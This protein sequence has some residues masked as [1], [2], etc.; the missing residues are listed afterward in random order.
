[1]VPMQDI[2]RRSML[3][4]AACGFGY[5]AFSALAAS[6]ARAAA[7]TQPATAGGPPTPTGYLNPLLPRPS[8]FAPR[9]KR[10]I[11]LFMQGGPSH[12]D[13]FDYKPQ[14]IKDAGKK[15]EKGSLLAPQFAFKQHGKSG[16]WISDLFP[17]IASHADEMCILNGMHTDNPAHPQATIALHT[18][19]VQFVRPSVGAWV[20]YGLGTVNQNLPG[21][22]TINPPGRLGGTQNYGNAFLPAAY[23]GTRI[24]GENGK[25]SQNIP[26]LVNDTMP[27]PMQRRQLDL[28]QSMNRDL[29]ERLGMDHDVEGVIE[30]YELAFR[31][32]STVPEVM[33]TAGESKQTLDL[34][35]INN[36][37]TSRF[38]MQC[39]MAR[40]FA[41]QGVRYIEVCHAG[42]D[43]HNNLKAKLTSNSREIDQPIGALLTDLSQRG[44]LEETLVIWGG[45]FGRT[46]SGQNG[47]GRNHNNRGY[48]MWMAGGGVKGGT[49][50]GATDPHGSSAVEGKMHTHDLHATTLALMGL[51]HER[52]TYRYSGRD[53]RLTDVAGK[54]ARAIL[55]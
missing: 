51:D 4:S 38:G 24:G 46:P 36:S 30:S 1:M 23:Q 25:E 28:V 26:N 42:W 11:F 40:R 43:Q 12:V 3:R 49:A 18:G 32:Q 9:A 7:L 50:F 37:A 10:V 8:H 48:S 39:L 53:F 2:S 35:G 52:L 15:G 54:V 31:M 29:V 55:A 16:L 27:Q 44:M 47:D 45:E 13:T 34:Y 20:L 22:I 19:S 41:E 14:L 17:N 6:E 33:N 5:M 21:F